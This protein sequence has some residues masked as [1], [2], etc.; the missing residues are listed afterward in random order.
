MVRRV[1]VRAD[2]E[3]NAATA[4]GTEQFVGGV[5]D[6]GRIADPVRVELDGGAR[7]GDRV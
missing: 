7:G 2:D 5:H 1:G 4:D 3:R 6:A